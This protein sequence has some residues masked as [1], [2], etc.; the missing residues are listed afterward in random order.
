MEVEEGSVVAMALVGMSGG[1]ESG[2]RVSAWCAGS[3]VS[4]TSR[5]RRGKWLRL[6]PRYF[7]AIG[8]ACGG[9]D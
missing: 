5:D 7:L 8:L 4:E 2:V 1:R 9:V 6:R 3:G